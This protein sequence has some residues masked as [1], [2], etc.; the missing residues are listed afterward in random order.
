[1]EQIIR[2]GV[3][4]TGIVLSAPQPA[5]VIGIIAVTL[6]LFLMNVVLLL[7][8]RGGPFDEPRHRQRQRG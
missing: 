2:L 5:H 3:V 8:N 1:M 4:A 6:V 7:L